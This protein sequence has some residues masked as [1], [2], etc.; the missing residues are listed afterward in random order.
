[1]TMHRGPRYHSKIN[2][3]DGTVLK[4]DLVTHEQIFSGLKITKL[5]MSSGRGDHLDAKQAYHL[6]LKV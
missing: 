1:M 5:R 3:P 4:Q 6:F 2:Q